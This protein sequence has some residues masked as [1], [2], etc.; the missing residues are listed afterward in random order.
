MLL[1]FVFRKNV[2]SRDRFSVVKTKAVCSSETS[3]LH[4]TTEYGSLKTDKTSSPQTNGAGRN[5]L[6]T[7]KIACL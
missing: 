1:I 6:V 7:E 2:T 3:A 5:F 4:L